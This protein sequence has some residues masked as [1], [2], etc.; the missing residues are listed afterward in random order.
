MILLS[1]ELLYTTIAA[2]ILLVCLLA[3]LDTDECFGL[4]EELLIYRQER[5]DFYGDAHV[6]VLDHLSGDVAVTL[7]DVVV[8]AGERDLK[9]IQDSVLLLHLCR[10]TK[11][12]LTFS[13]PFFGFRVYPRCECLSFSTYR[14]PAHNRTFAILVDLSPP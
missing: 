2:F 8:V 11:D 9:I 6:G 12:T 14:H 7:F 1:D 13:V 10:S 3:F 5:L 4:F